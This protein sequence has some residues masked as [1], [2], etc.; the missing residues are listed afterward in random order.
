MARDSTTFTRLADGTL[1]L[2]HADG[3]YRPVASETERARLDSLT[4]AEIEAM[5]SSDPDHPGLDDA[6]WAAATA[7][8]ERKQSRSSSTETCWPI[9]EIR[10]ADIKA[11]S[12]PFSAAISN[13]GE[14][15]G[16]RPP[17]EPMLLNLT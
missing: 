4:E 11:A 6:F 14:R 8:R 13:R 3:S 17:S 5:A 12:M 16:D 15:Q 10:D 7:A 1:L 9:S 2:R